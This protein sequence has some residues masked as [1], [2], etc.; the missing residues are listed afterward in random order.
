MIHL[1]AQLGLGALTFAFVDVEE[2]K[3]WV[4]DYYETFKRECTPI[5]QTVNP[6]IAM[7]T[8]FSCHEDE[9]R[10]GAARAGGLPVLRLRA[11]PLLPVRRARAR[12]H[13]ASGTSSRRKP[14]ADAG[15]AARGIGTP[16]DVRAALR[17]FEEAG[18]DQAIFIQQGGNNRHADIC[19]ALE[20]FATDVMPEFRERHEARQRQKAEQLAPSI[21]RALARRTVPPE[22]TEL[23]T[24]RAYG[25]SLSSGA[26]AYPKA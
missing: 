10:G 22:P 5:A 18:V 13:R 14:D 23:P 24:V 15:L 21:E 19:A 7:V 25:R 9:Q 8:G 12:P 3:H 17:V 11:R 26:S 2:A 20:L 4:A 16:D 1:A 6:N